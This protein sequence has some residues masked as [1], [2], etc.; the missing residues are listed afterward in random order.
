M[1]CKIRDKYMNNPKTKEIL[2]KFYEGRRSKKSI[3][4]NNHHFLNTCMNGASVGCI[5]I[6]ANDRYR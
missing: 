1:Q 6:Y 3:C 2:N 4:L 5:G